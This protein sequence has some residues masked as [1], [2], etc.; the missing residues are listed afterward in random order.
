LVVSDLTGQARAIDNG[1]PALGAFATPD[2]VPSQAY[3]RET[4]AITPAMK[5]DVSRVVQVETTGKQMV[6]IEGEIAPQEPIGLYPGNGNQVFYDYPAGSVRTEYV[7]PLGQ[8]QPL[9]FQ[10]VSVPKKVNPAPEVILP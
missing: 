8:T 2:L 1:K 4:L 5:A 3:A 6:Q 10:N 9:P 7:K